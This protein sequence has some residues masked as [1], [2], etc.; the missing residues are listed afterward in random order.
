MKDPGVGIIFEVGTEAFIDEPAAKHW[1]Q[2]R[3][4]HFDAPE[5]IPIHPV[6]AGQKYPVIA[7][8]EKIENAA[9]LEKS[10]DDGAYANMFRKTGDSRSQ[11][12]GSP[13]DQINSDAGLRRLVQRANN[14]RPRRAT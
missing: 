2:H 6:R 3:K 11:G 13:H 1:I 4:R 5:K 12:A 10:P 14:L 8:I 9:V 7:V